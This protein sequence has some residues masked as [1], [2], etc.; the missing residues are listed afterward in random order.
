MNSHVD[1]SKTT[2]IATKPLPSD[3]AGLDLTEV[4]RLKKSM[5]PPDDPF[6]R[7]LF[8]NVDATCRLNLPP[9]VSRKQ[10]TR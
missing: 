7:Q 6:L 9:V 10:E 8:R 4:R 3:V 2:K 1:T 5:K